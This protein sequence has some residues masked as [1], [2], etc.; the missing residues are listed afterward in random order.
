M[1]D[2]LRSHGL[3]HTRLPCPSLSPGV[4]SNLCPLSRWCYPTIS[5]SVTPLS[6][7][8]QSFP[9]SGSFP[10]N[11]FFASGGQSR[12]ASAL[13]SVLPMNNQGWFPSVRQEPSFRPWKGS[14]FLQQMATL[15]GTLL[16]WDWHPYHLGYSGASLPAK[17][18]D[19][20]AATGTLL[21]LVSSWCGQLARVPWPGKERET[22]LTSLPFPLS[23]LSLT[24]PILP[25]FSSPPVLNA[26][27]WSKGL[28]LSWGLETD[29]LLLA[30]NSNSGSGLVW[31]LVGSSSSLPFS[32]GPG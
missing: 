7:C 21:S 11:Q 17:G 15:A 9:A 12:G 29:H 22:L 8:P 16:R 23:F 28:S 14:A 4:C 32:G 13:A 30:E 18:P 24:L 2:S 6:S 26:G 3:Q 31:F 25:R 10:M 1:S 20:V 5:T 27:I 19:P